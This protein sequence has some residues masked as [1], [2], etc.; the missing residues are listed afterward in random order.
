MLNYNLLY[1]L[2]FILFFFGNNLWDFSFGCHVHTYVYK[3]TMEMMILFF[4]TIPR[5]RF[6][7][8]GKNTS[9]WSIRENSTKNAYTHTHTCTKCLSLDNKA[10]VHMQTFRPSP[11]FI[12]TLNFDLVRPFESIW[13]SSKI[14]H[15]KLKCTEQKGTRNSIWSKAIVSSFYGVEKFRLILLL[16]PSPSLPHSLFTERTVRC[17]LQSGQARPTTEFGEGIASSLKK[18][19]SGMPTFLPHSLIGVPQ[20]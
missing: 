1:L 3:H 17:C 20:L 19:F 6:D 2:F 5:N 9:R 10:H 12:L 14:Q 8:K 11:L 16:F 7:R 4:M 15:K 13:S 18:V